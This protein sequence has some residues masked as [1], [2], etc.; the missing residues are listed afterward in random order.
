MK[1]SLLLLR[2]VIELYIPAAAFM[3]MF[4]AFVLQVFCRYVVNRPLTW[5]NDIIVIGFVWTVILGACYTMRGRKHVKF[6]LVFDKLGPRM[7]A[8]TRFLGNLIIVVT[9]VALIVP[10]YKYSLFL[11]FQKT[12]VFRVSYTWVFMPF[13]YFV[14]SI[15]G[16]TIPELIEDLRV[17]S[18]K[19][20]DS[21]DHAEAGG[22]V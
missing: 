8:L 6:T 16:Y 14:I 18:G 7:A 12:P 4:L 11:D 9:F 5:T 19:L 21:K 2:N 13:V 15:I 22:K 20:P 17:M 1:K 3:A 10:S